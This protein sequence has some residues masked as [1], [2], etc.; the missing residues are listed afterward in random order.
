MDLAKEVSVRERYDWRDGQLDLD[1]GEFA[2]SDARFNVV[3]YDFGVKRNILRML[4]ERGCDVTVVPAQT[5]AARSAGDE[6]GRRVPVQR[7]RRS[8][9]LRLRDRRDPRI[10]REE[11][12]RPSASA[13]ATSCSASPSAPRR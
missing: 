13:W 5:P 6:A 9:A 7:P 3:A 1:R 10:H 11:D 4:A 2:R 12:S 8:G